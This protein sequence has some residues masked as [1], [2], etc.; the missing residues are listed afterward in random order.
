MGVL[1]NDFHFIF[2]PRNKRLLLNKKEMYDTLNVQSL[3][4]LFQH[5]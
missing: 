3:D 1:F 2:G 4:W 5:L